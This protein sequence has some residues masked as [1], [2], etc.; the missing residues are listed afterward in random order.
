MFVQ[1]PIFVKRR[2]HVHLFLH[3]F[4]MPI[5]RASKRWS[6]CAPPHANDSNT[7]LATAPP[8][9]QLRTRVTRAISR[10]NCFALDALP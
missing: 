10:V 7:N 4:C 3:F 1:I 9:P 8:P 2:L 6:G 5:A